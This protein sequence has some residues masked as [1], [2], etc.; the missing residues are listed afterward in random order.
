[1]KN[2][3]IIF[4]IV[5]GCLVI[6]AEG[7]MLYATNWTIG[8]SPDS[9]IY[10]E[11]ARNI[12]SGVGLNIAPGETLTHFPP[13]Y[14]IFLAIPGLIGFDPL[15]GV[16]W[17]H[18]FLYAA[19]VLLVTTIIYRETN[20][21]IMA[22]VFG[23]LFM[24]SSLSMLDIHTMAWS[25]AL[26]LLLT[27]AGFFVLAEYLADPENFALLV[28]SSLFIGAAC[29][30]RY[31]GVSVVAAASLSVLFLRNGRISQKVKYASI[32]GA[33]SIL[34][35]LFWLSRNRL[36]T[37]KLTDRTAQ[38][39]PIDLN[40]I[41][42]GITTIA[43]W[44]LLPENLSSFARNISVIIFICLLV[45]GTF[46][47]YVKRKRAVNSLSATKIFYF[48]IISIVLF[49]VYLLTLVIS[50]S[51]FDAHTPLD[52]RILSPLFPLGVITLFAL[53]FNAIDNFR[54][55]RLYLLLVM[56]LAGLLAYQMKIT[57]PYFRY[58]HENGRWYTGKQWQ[59]SN[60]M[61]IVKSLPDNIFL[62]SNG[63]DAIELLTRKKAFRIPAVEAPGTVRKNRDF[64]A[65]LQEMAEKLKSANGVLVYFNLI[66]WRW[67][68]PTSEYLNENLP[69][70]IIYQG[71]DGAI[72]QVN[73]G[74]EG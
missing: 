64:D 16:R 24:I 28:I 18:V 73:N 51:F 11:V 50:I 20:G 5:T 25:E 46:L 39:H 8:V 42:Q 9:T 48:P 2:K 61:K 27:L 19:N 35:I 41:E 47:F 63:D 21:S 62:Y 65:D 3:L 10:I 60:I 52:N 26:F 36:I 49:G 57:L 23:A 54:M 7:A 22:S 55:P 37:D 17:L 45:S 6:I 74:K 40:R 12:I 68:L 44:F 66:K 4:A 32:Y 58:A 15:D 59:T 71:S 43:E 30:T 29:L 14:P 13:L 34:P 72:F 31:I 69:L 38:Y 56:L 1:M 53:I 33:V 67:Y 70:Q